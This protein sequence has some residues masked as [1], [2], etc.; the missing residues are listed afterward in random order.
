MT[1]IAGPIACW[2]FGIHLVNSGAHHSGAHPQCQLERRRGPILRTHG[3]MG[4]DHRMMT[5]SAA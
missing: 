1:T 2:F 4:E 3:R 5:K